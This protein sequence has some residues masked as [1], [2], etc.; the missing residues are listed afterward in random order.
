MPARDEAALIGRCIGALACQEDVALDSYE[1]IVVLDGCR[2]GT[3]EVL[4]KTTAKHPHLAVR[5]LELSVPVPASTPKRRRSGTQKRFVV[6]EHQRHGCTG[7]CAWST[8]GRWRRGLSRTGSRR[9]R[10]TTVRRSM[11]RIIR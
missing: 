9:I 11:S 7:I 6:H 2:D 1:V 8:T 3:A 4:R 5:P 10:S